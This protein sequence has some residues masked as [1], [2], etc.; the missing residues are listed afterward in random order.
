MLFKSK[1]CHNAAFDLACPNRRNKGSIF[2][3]F[4]IKKFAFTSIKHKEDTA[5]TYSIV[6]D[7]ELTHDAIKALEVPW[8]HEEKQMGVEQRGT[9]IKEGKPLGS[10][11]ESIYRVKQIIFF[12]QH[13]CD[14]KL[15]I[16]SERWLARTVYFFCK[17]HTNER[18]KGTHT[19]TLLQRCYCRT[20]T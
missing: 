16:P 20:S 8:W 9:N 5:T 12:V 2:P 1:L 17:G 11:K 4:N 7:I 13:L 6:A 15:T 3:R 19:V 18:V 14:R 10:T